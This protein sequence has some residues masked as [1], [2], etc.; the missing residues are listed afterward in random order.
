MTKFAYYLL[1]GITLLCGSLF[2]QT[3][4]LTAGTKQNDS[5]QQEV[6]SRMIHCSR[7][8]RI[9]K[10]NLMGWRKAILKQNLQLTNL[11]K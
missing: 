3:D 11:K 6:Q 8:Y 4:S 9:L 1:P 5:L 10:V 7:R 2:A